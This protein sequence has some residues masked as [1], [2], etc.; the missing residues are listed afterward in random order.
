MDLFTE[1]ANKVIKKLN[2]SKARNPI[3]A[4]EEDAEA[5][6]TPDEKKMGMDKKSIA[7]VNVAQK[8]ATKPGTL[9]LPF[10]GAQA[11]MNSAYG[12][13]M[14]AMANKINNIANNLK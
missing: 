6:D 11:K 1:K 4:K 2:A 8:L 7:A 5:A 9:N 3:E 12:N 14:K 10:I 13:L